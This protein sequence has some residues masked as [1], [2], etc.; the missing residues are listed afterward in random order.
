MTPNAR[1]LY[2]YLRAR[3]DAVTV[4]QIERESGI[5]RSSIYEAAQRY[6]DTFTLTGSLIATTPPTHELMRDP[7]STA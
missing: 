3:G 2:W 6:P 5:P 1:A 7:H 4:T